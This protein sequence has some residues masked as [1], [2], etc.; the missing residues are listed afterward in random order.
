MSQLNI[1][2]CRLHCSN[3]LRTCVEQF[4]TP[5]L[6][7]TGGATPKR[8]RCSGRRRG[9]PASLTSSSTL[10]QSHCRG[11]DFPCQFAQSRAGK[12]IIAGSSRKIFPGRTAWSY[13]STTRA[14]TDPFTLPCRDWCFAQ[15]PGRAAQSQ[16]IP[17]GGEVGTCLAALSVL[18][19]K[20]WRPVWSPVALGPLPVPAGKLHC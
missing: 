10:S 5:L 17:S 20:R 6:Q 3:S 16:A 15:Q 8:Q 4:H 2:G 14:C 18:P 13:A 7:A 12:I 9:C 1:P 19:P 11:T